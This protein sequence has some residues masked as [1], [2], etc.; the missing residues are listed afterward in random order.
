MRMG[1][2][3]IIHRMATETPDAGA[4]FSELPYADCPRCGDPV[5]PKPQYFHPISAMLHG[6][7]CNAWFELP[8]KKH[9]FAHLVFQRHVER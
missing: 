9:R 2:H 4:D 6:M 7:N 1:V 8:A 3:G 5:P